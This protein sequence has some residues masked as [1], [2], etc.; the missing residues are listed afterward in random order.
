MGK[1]ANEIMQAKSLAKNEEYPDATPAV[2][3]ALAEAR[4]QCAA[5]AADIAG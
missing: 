3:L 4:K 5:T 1:R 2:H